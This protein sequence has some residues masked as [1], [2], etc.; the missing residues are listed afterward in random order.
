M[1]PSTQYPV[2]STQYPVPSTLALSR[3]DVHRNRADLAANRYI[4][5]RARFRA[6]EI[7]DRIGHRSRR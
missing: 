5:D 1:R 6:S 7:P 2:P 4:T 3:P